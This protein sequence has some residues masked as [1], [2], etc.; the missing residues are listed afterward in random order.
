M[1]SVQ[2]I[3]TAMTRASDLRIVQ[4]NDIGPHYATTLADW[5]EDLLAWLYVV[6]ALAFDDCFIRM[7]LFY[8]GCSE[9]GFHGRNVGTV[10][11]LLA[12]PQWRGE[13]PVRGGSA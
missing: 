5:R 12:R 8:L 3:S 9:G 11:M 1:F 7:W 10:Q 2:A 4:L 13:F 6:R